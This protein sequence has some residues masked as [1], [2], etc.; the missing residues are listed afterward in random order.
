MHKI[1]IANRGAIARRVVRACTNA[2]IASV[3]VY[4]D[5]DADAPYLSEATEAYVLPGTA[6]ADTYLNQ[7]AILN[8]AQQAGVDGVHPGYGFLAEN[9]DFAQ[10]VIDA[11]MTFIGPQPQWL[12]RMGDKVA[13]RAL[14]SE[15][16]FPVFAGS[17]LIEDPAL[18][19]SFA[20]DIGYPVIVKP[21]GGGGGMG[22]VVVEDAAHL[23]DAIKRAQAVAKQAFATTG[24]YLERFVARPR[25]IEYQILGDGRGGAIHLYERE[26]SVQR[27]N[28]KLIEES[29][30]PGLD[31]LLIQQ[32]A[33][34]AA[35]VC[36]DL[37]YDNVGT[38]ETLFAS[39]GDM[40]FLEMNTR[41]QVEHGVTEAI[42]GCDL[43]QL[44]I[45]LAQGGE[46]P[47]QP[48]R[49]GFAMEVRLYAEDPET[50]LPST[51]RL[52]VFRPP[53]LHGVRVESGYQE[54]QQVTP[55]Y[56]AMLAK[57]IA[58]A[59]TRELAIGRLLVALR[60]FEVVG[61]KTNAPLLMK[62]LQNAAFLEGDVDTGIVDRVMGEG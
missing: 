49:H 42:T 60:A 17:G 15:H 56:D 7:T 31:P 36:A 23:E 25:H 18:A 13:A 58:H 59:E 11:G 16:G 48:T 20:D 44:Q 34:M 4:S 61:V 46:L 33:D 45:E 2:G 29:P 22:M 6:S 40:G 55:H 28:Q 39:N 41:I 24:V 51:G 12:R 57:L 32:R 47:V 8:I 50:L 14:L 19:R 35:A 52:S 10:A 27:R 3:V 43:I 1:L 5:A 26:C 30:A 9:A 37:G 54:G 62:I 21:S 38:L 53:Q